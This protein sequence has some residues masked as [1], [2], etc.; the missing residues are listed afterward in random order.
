LGILTKEKGKGYIISDIEKLKQLE[1][2]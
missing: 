2:K 1:D